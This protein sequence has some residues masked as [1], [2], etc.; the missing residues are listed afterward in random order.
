MENRTG[1]VHVKV[2]VLELVLYISYTIDELKQKGIDIKTILFEGDVAELA[3]TLI[4][5]YSF[6]S[7]LKWKFEHAALINGCL[8]C[9]AVKMD[10]ELNDES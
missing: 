6:H 4:D 1:G 7:N 9:K 8:I 2:K 3:Q 10:A 5:E